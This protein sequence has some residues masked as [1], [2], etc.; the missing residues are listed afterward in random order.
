MVPAPRAGRSLQ[1]MTTVQP[2][3]RAASHSRSTSGPGTV[4][5]ESQSR[6]NQRLPSTGFSSQF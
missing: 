2:W 1:P 5:A 3:V 4:M 6:R